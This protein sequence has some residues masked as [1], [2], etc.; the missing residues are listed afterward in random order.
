[1]KNTFLFLFIVFQCYVVQSQSCDP[2]SLQTI[3][4]RASQTDPNISWELKQ[5]YSFYNPT[6]ISRNTLLIHLGGSFGKPSNYLIFPELAANNGFH[7]INLHY[8]NGTAAKTACG[9]SNDTNCFGKF[10]KEIIEGIDFSTKVSVDSN[11]CINNRV[12]KLLQYLHSNYPTQNWNSFYTGNTVNWNKVIV[13]G[14]SQGGGHAA[15]IGVSKPLKRVI[16]FASPN[17]YNSTLNI[18]AL[19]TTNTKLTADSLYY[20]FV[21]LNDEVVNSSEQFQ[22]WSNLGMPTYGDTTNVDASPFPYSNSRQLYT[23]VSNSA[24]SNHSIM[25]LDSDV[26]VV[27]GKPIFETEWK[28]LLGIN[29]AT[30]IQENKN[31]FKFNIYPNP[32]QNQLIIDSDFEYNNL[33]V[34]S[35]SGAVVYSQANSNSIINIENLKPGVYYLTLINNDKRSTKKFIKLSK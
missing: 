11:N 16:M 6:C 14:H 1:M 25:I 29:N 26:P 31:N 22:I 23:Q 7:V 21:H 28:Y 24:A 33:I 34:Q 13:S 18:P 20:G 15:F 2:D 35:V 30:S 10:R 3:I 12:I 32:T 19:W 27:G 9:T 4:T 17:D 5:H 8:P